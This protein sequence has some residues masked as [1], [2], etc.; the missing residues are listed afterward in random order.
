[1]CKLTIIIP[2]YNPGKNLIKCMD[3][4]LNQADEAIEIL[5]V[6]DG[7]T[8]NSEMIIKEY[9]EKYPD[10]ITYYKK[11][12]TGV[13][14]TRNFA[15]S[16]AKGKYFVFVDSDDYI[17]DGLIKKL[18]EYISDEID[19]VKFKLERVD[20]S[21][22]II[23]KVDGPV[24]E[25]TDGQTAFNMLCFS[26]VLLDSPC[27]YMFKKELFEGNDLKFKVNTEHE[28][29]GLIPLVLLKAKTIVSIEDFS[30]CYLQTTGSI[31]RNEDYQKT[32]KKFNDALLHYDAMIEFISNEDL[33]SIT[34]KNIKTYYTNAII[35][36]LKD[37][38]SQ[39]V[40]LYIKKIKKRNMIDNIQVNNIRQFIKKA[41][42]RINIKWYIK[43]K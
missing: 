13:A 21:G 1:M 33:T 18:K 32:L 14:D 36:K 20:D 22:N 6:N 40:N 16:K 42:L 12:N 28:D 8:D 38:K 5:V 10:I 26:D 39:D 25:K 30:Y 7:S 34:K 37:I 41:I 29:F 4:I 24:F 43:L 3:S 35:L 2:V 23:E 27:V 19:I 31:T 9:E 15:I 11:G 17:K